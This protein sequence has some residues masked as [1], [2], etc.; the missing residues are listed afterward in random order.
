[1]LH[2]SALTFKLLLAPTSTQVV[3]PVWKEQDEH[4]AEAEA[5]VKQWY[6][7]HYG[8]LQSMDE[9]LW[10]VWAGVNISNFIRL[11]SS[12]LQSCGCIPPTTGCISGCI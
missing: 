5:R 6:A 3:R 7:D 2:L 11:W 10:Q 9:H 1:M 4:V 12:A 8:G